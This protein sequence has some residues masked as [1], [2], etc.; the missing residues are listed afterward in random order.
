MVRGYVYVETG[1]RVGAVSMALFREVGG[2]GRDPKKCGERTL[3]SDMYTNG[4][5]L[6]SRV[7]F[8]VYVAVD[9]GSALCMVL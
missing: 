9:M 5:W 1:M 2:W 3:S 7:G 8:G 4:S 6:G